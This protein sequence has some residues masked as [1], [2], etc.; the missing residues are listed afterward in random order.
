MSARSVGCSS[1]VSPFEAHC[2]LRHPSL[3]VLKKLCPQF[4]DVHVV[5]CESCHFIKH[6]RSSLGPWIN[7]QADF[8]FE[9]VHSNILG[10]CPVASKGCLRYFVTFVD[11]FFRMTWIYFMKNRSEVF[12]HFSKFCVEIK[13]NIYVRT[14]RS[15][16]A[17]EHMPTSFQNYM[18]QHRILHQS[19]CVDT[20]SK[21]SG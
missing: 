12:S 7:K 15:N 17:K 10:P 18:S 2:R 3:P 4:H 8:A 5:E 1:V 19:S 11:D 9:L 21:W 13:T 14:L 16:N 20:L 6:H